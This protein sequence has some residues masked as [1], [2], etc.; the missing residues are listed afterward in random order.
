M[1]DDFKEIAAHQNFSATKRKEENSGV[2]ELVENIFDLRRGHLA[3]IIVIQIAM[4]APLIAAIGESRCTLM[5]MPSP[6]AF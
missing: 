4:N 3:V 5:G 1:F 2:R 6:S